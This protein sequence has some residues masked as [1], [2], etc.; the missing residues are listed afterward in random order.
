MYRS[1]V[2]TCQTSNFYFQI[3]HTFDF[4]FN[5]YVYYYLKYYDSHVVVFV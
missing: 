3:A 5:N 2:K 1:Y 4:F